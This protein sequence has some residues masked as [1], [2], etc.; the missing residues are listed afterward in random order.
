MGTNF[1]W[2]ETDRE[3]VCDHCHQ[4]APASKLHIGKSSAGWVFA[5][6][7]HPELGINSLDDWKRVWASGG[8]IRDEYGE[9][10]TTEAML[11]RITKR[12]G[13]DRSVQRYG[14]GPFTYRSEAEM[15]RRNSAMFHPN[16]LLRADPKSRNWL[17]GNKVR[18]GE[19]GGT[20]DYHEGEFS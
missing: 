5:V 17:G 7:V 3:Q 10:H 12:E 20:F 14:D 9:T 6:R 13:R 15:L 18:H 4:T 1:Y 8:V 11:D 16:G 19:D 2:Q